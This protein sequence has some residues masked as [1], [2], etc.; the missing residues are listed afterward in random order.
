MPCARLTQGFG[1]SGR[2]KRSDSIGLGSRTWPEGWALKPP[3]LFPAMGHPLTL[4]F[5]FLGVCMV[6]PPDS[7]SLPQAELQSFPPLLSFRN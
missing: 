6:T 1:V 5:C 7:L 3:L 2:F 4:P